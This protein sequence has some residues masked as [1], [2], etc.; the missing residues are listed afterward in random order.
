MRIGLDAR[1]V[2]DHFPGIGRYVVNLA[3]GLAQLDHPHT[4]V[5]LH[6]PDLANT[7]HDIDSLAT[8]PA[9]ELSPTR[10]RPF[11]LAEHLHIPRLARALRLDLLHSPDYLKPYFGLP[12]PSVI[13]IYDLI[14][15]RFPDA[16]PPRARHLFSLATWL[17]LR[18]STR[19]LAISQSTRDDVLRD[20]RLPPRR[21][22]VTPLAADERFT[23]QPPAA[24]E[25]VRAAYSLPPR[26]VLYLGANKPH[27]NLE[28]LVQAWDTLLIKA[29]QEEKEATEFA[30]LRL[31]LAGHHDPRYPQV[32]QF[33]EE[34][35]F[36]ERVMFLPNVGEA[37]LP[38]LY[39]GAEVFAFPSLY[40]GFGLP[41]LEAM[42]CG[43]PVLCSRT[44]SLPEVVG[45]AAVAVDPSSTAEMAEGL[46]RLL[47]T[48]ALRAD[49]REKG[50]ERAR[51]FS[52]QRTA[53][54]TL[55]VYE[56]VA[57]GNP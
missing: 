37:D 32:R 10:A 18:T 34:R 6:N 15:R 2:Y 16:L 51:L 50:L 19:V 33:V 47:T 49:L 31:V 30:A 35:G 1:Y 36:A 41:P 48:P 42:A 28:R 17:A 21:V 57:S 4:L 27:K 11:S 24:V 14:G 23:P 8:L 55:A 46:H 53:R 7:R 22:I 12:C 9:V 3:R 5:L 52:W 56:E 26:Y 40:E 43:V 44:S 25:A 45:D 29:Q 13:T 38:A 20:Y 54:E 39:S